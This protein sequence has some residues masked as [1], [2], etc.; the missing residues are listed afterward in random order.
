MTEGRAGPTR[1]ARAAAACALAAALALAP[2]CLVLPWFTSARTGSLLAKEHVA[3]L[4]AGTSRREVLERFGPPLAVARR[5]GGAAPVPEVTMRRCGGAEQPEA[6]FFE[7]FAGVAAGPSDVVYLYR[8][9]ERRTE[10]SGAALVI[11]NKGGLVGSS[12]DEE[13]EDRLWILL[14]GETGLVKAHLHERDE[15]PPEQE[16]G[17]A[18]GDGAP[19]EAQW[20]TQ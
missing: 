4:R 9:H 6:W 16:A 7:R 15:P 17:A 18:N 8:E 10:G 20:G 13:R 5:G 11:G 19:G 3:A 2:G 1:T 12:T 14:D